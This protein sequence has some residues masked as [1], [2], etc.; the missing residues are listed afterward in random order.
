MLE[1][2]NKLQVL[3]TVAVNFLL[4]VSQTANLYPCSIDDAARIFLP[5]Y[6]A[7]WIRIEV[8][9]VAPRPGTI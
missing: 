3:Q 5:P 7:A 1:W 9:R 4:L 6:A 2:I 8:S